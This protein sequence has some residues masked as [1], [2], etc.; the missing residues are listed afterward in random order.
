M[1]ATK[2]EGI[3]RE[4]Q[5]S[6][7]VYTSLFRQIHELSPQFDP[8]A[9]VLTYHPTHLPQTGN[10]LVAFLSLK[11]KTLNIRYCIPVPA[12]LGIKGIKT[13]AFLNSLYLETLVEV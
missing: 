8:N 13:G 7:E 10:F 12:G 9:I 6:F 1:V 2:V 5:R 11:D 4:P 3:F